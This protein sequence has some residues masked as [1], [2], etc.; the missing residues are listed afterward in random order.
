MA[1]TSVVRAAAASSIACRSADSCALRSVISMDVP[2][3]WCVCPSSPGN[4][5]AHDMH[6]ADFAV[7]QHDAVLA[8]EAAARIEGRPDQLAVMLLIIGMHPPKKLGT[9]RHGFRRVGAI[10]PVHFLRPMDGH[11]RWLQRPA[12]QAGDALG[13]RQARFARPGV[14]QDRPLEGHGYLGVLRAVP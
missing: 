9:H 11:R 3:S 8:V 1:S 10:E 4:R 14:S 5:F 12:P 13:F 7:R 6:P 2:R